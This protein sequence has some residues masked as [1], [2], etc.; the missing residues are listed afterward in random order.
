VLSEANHFIGAVSDID[1]RVVLV[2]IVEAGRAVL[3]FAA[4][5]KKTSLDT[6]GAPS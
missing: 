2:V 3:H 6:S 1:G 4:C 5:I